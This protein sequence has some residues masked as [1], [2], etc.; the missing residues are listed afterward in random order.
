MWGEHVT[1]HRLSRASVADAS[2]AYCRLL[3]AEQLQNA[4]VGLV[5]LR[6]HGGTGL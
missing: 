2:A 5:C 6:E 3:L 4:L 1:A